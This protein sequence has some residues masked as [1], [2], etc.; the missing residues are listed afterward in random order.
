MNLR[1]AARGQ[2]CMVRLPGICNGDEATTVL[3]HIGIA[4]TRG[5]GFKG[6]DWCATFACSS[7]HDVLDSR[8]PSTLPRDYIKTCAME[9]MIR[10]LTLISTTGTLSVRA[11]KPYWSSR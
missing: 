4:G 6:P 7:C 11:G 2:P 8:T 1:D 5:M 9:G 3:A 10:T